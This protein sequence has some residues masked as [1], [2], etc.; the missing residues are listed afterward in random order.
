MS[1]TATVAFDDKM[2]ASKTNCHWRKMKLLKYTIEVK[3]QNHFLPIKKLF[4]TC[5]IFQSNLRK[6]L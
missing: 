3:S 4:Y 6:L 1:S 5:S 2:V